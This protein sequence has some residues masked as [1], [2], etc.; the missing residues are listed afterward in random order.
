MLVDEPW[1]MPL[2]IP[3]G[4]TLELNC[5]SHER[6]SWLID[7][8]QNSTAGIPLSFDLIQEQLNAHGV[9]ELPQIDAP[10]MPS[11]L[12]LLINDTARNNQTLIRCQGA[13]TFSTTTLFVLG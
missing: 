10:G 5:T 1:P 12:R 6:R 3:S 13:T 7:L 8:R 4:S 2:F 9:F 11:T